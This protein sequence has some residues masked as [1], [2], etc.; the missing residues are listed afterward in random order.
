[1]FKKILNT[2]KKVKS[3]SKPDYIAYCDLP[4]DENLV[5]LEGGQGS[6]INGNMF[7]MLKELCENKRWASYKPVFVVTSATLEKAKARMAFYGFRDVIL[8]V[9][10]SKSYLK[11]L[12]TA[13]YLMTDNTFPPYFNKREGQVYL[14]TWHGTPLKTLGKSNK[15]SL[16]SL[17]NVQKNYLS[18]DYAL[19]PNEFTRDVF[20]NDYDLAPVFKN[21][22]FIGNYPRNYI[23]Y[24]AQAGENL[25]EK[26]GFKGKKVFAY[27]PTWRDADTPKEKAEQLKKTEEILDSFESLLDDSTVLLVNL[28][29]LLSSE[30]DCGKYKHISYFSSDYDTYEILNAC[31]GLVTD[32]S[33]VFFD[34]AVTGKKVILFAYD[35]AEYL[36]NRGLYMPFEDLPFPIV[37]KAEDVVSLLESETE[38]PQ[39]FISE[40]CPK[41]W[42]NT[43]EHVF[44]MMVTGE[45][46]V[47]E[48]TEN[49]KANEDITLI[50]G[51]NLTGNCCGAIK[52]F[53]D[54]NP[55]GKYVVAYRRA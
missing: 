6:N 53:V 26:L 35:K 1:M 19:F 17:A 52:A 30:I 15:S 12:A 39:E 20:M 27:M 16:A 13:K 42:K 24:D 9:R 47:F 18:S 34:F 46:E 3:S 25:K 54:E 32:Y 5:L 11:Y 38:V 43:C 51:G 28:H 45:S 8:S 31:D 41:G 48:L 44:E 29:F 10:D 2:I 33:S 4:I 50:Y 14:N 40:Y 7:A 36:S 49:E 55:Q 23:F 22:S 37:E 21:K